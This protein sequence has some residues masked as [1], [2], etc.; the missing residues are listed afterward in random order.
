MQPVFAT[1]TIKTAL[2]LAVRA[3]GRQRQRK[4]QGSVTRQVLRRLLAT[5]ALNRLVDRR[6]RALLLTAFASGGRRR[7]EMASLRVEQIETLPPVRA[8]PR[9]PESTKLP[10]LAIRLSRTKRGD[11]D[12]GSRVLLIG[13]PA[14]ALSAWLEHAEITAGAVFRPIDRWSRIGARAISGD[15]VNGIVKRRCKQAGLDPALFSAHGLRS[16]YLT[17]AALD[18]VALP[19]A[20]QQSQHRS[21]Q[22]AAE[23]YNDGERQM[24]KAARLYWR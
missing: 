21:V 24:G 14:D 2:R 1:P 6:D 18:G 15:G 19:E 23:Y 5:C 13:Y 17:Q 8:D 16:G 3:N 7:S 22:Q 20:M 4:S 10:C 9:D 11:A 12:D